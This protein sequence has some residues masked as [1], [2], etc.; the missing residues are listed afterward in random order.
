MHYLKIMSADIE[1]RIKRNLNLNLN[2]TLS[3]CKTALR[4]QIHLCSALKKGTGRNSL[5]LIFSI[6]RKF[7]PK[8]VREVEFAESSRNKME[9]KSPRLHE[10]K[11]TSEF[12][13]TKVN[14]KSQ[15]MEYHTD[16]RS[17]AENSPHFQPNHASSFPIPPRYNRATNRA[18]AQPNIKAR[19]TTK[20]EQNKLKHTALELP[21]APGWCSIPAR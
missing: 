17:E 8:Y 1:F 11:I 3:R 19:T 15:Y 7:Q 12:R 4:T 14:Y 6:S 21:P 20:P 13:S 18:P 2:G 9:F 16:A 10:A 5:A